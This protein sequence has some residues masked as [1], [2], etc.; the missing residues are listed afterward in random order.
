MFPVASA[1][2][3]SCTPASYPCS[4]GFQLESFDTASGVA[5]DSAAVAALNAGKISAY[6]F[7]LTPSQASSVPSSYSKL[8]VPNSLYE[9]EVNP[10]AT[11]WSSVSSLPGS[12]FNPFYYPQIRQAFNYLMDRSFLVDSSSALGGAGVATL[13][14]Y[15]VA[16]D[17]LTV[18][19][20]TAPYSSFLTDN[21]ALANST[22]YKT[23]SGVSG[24][25]Y[26]NHAW[27]Y[28]GS[29]ITIYV[30]N[31]VDDPIRSA[32]AGA[33]I[34]NLKAVGFAVDDESFTLATAETSVFVENP[35]TGAGGAP[36]KAWDLYF[37][38]FSGVYLY[39][40]DELQVCFDGANCAG[41]NGPYSDNLTAAQGAANPAQCAVND[42][43]M[44]KWDT[45]AQTPPD[46]IAISDK[47]DQLNNE[48]LAG[49]YTTYAQ[50]TAILNNYTALEIQLG[51]NDWAAAGFNEYSVNPSQLTGLSPQVTTSPILNTESAMTM[52]SASATEPIGVRYLTEYDLNPVGLSYSA[53]A[54]SAD[55]LSTEFPNL[56]ASFGAGTGGPVPFGWTYTID[57]YSP[58]ANIAVP[59][60]AV[61]YNANSTVA[62]T[63][64]VNATSGTMAKLAVTVNYANLMDHD[65]YSDNEPITMA[66]IIYPYIMANNVSYSASP[67]YVPAIASLLA[68]ELSTIIGLRVLNSTAI[69]FYSSYFFVAPVEAVTTTVADFTPIR[70]A[71]FPWT[72]YVAM[73]RQ[74]VGAGFSGTNVWDE[75][76]SNSSFPELTLVAN[77][78]EGNPTDISNIVSTLGTLSGTGYVP[79]QLVA[80]DSMFPGDGINPGSTNATAYYTDASTF[81]TSDTG[82][83]NAFIGFGP[84]YLSAWQDATT[85]H[86]AALTRNPNFHLGPYL[87]PELF[88]TAGD[89]SVST[90]VPTTI[91]PGDTIAMTTVL[92][93]LGSTT[94]SP[95]AG[96]NVTVQLVNSTSVV[97]QTRFVSGTGG[98]LTYT[99]P[100]VKTGAYSLIV[101]A[102]SVN[103]TIIVPQAYSVILALATATTSTSTSSTTAKAVIST[104]D[105]EIIAAV[106]VVVVIVAAVALFLRRRPSAT[107]PPA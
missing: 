16:P 81:I 5:D 42:C 43:A 66:D 22:I 69:E 21:I 82:S 12:A 97:A 102:S 95:L 38:A 37:G 80:L 25:T 33:V 50:R 19:N 9:I 92:T 89:I 18:A 105:Y 48:I 55:I 101:Y 26:T 10:E 6:D 86:T 87:N 51:V 49:T 46:V 40:G 78:A 99:V 3:S 74:I 104:T 85:P 84:M 93:P 71:Q 98:A 2:G 29:P 31:R 41:S 30:A 23:L 91:A 59:T 34:A 90:T 28:N 76:Q 39:Y 17:V 57:G 79:A 100:T 60:S 53:D 1:P 94:A 45:L 83:S 20:G 107:P 35:V 14:V 56:G 13:S 15:G 63:G 8:G 73:S 58:T 32:W 7:Q 11:T 52:T 64:W 88:A 44:G 27:Y 65:G 77:G 72:M 36:P 61:T 75:P 96:A 103:N 54:Y 62:P 106:V 47:L 70:D 24:V 67:M 4:S 68:S